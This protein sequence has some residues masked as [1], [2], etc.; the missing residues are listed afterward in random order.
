[1]IRKKIILSIILSCIVLLSGCFDS[2]KYPEYEI[3]KQDNG[4]YILNSPDGISY[5]TYENNIWY[6]IMPIMPFDEGLNFD[7]AIGKCDYGYIFETQSEA[8][9]FLTAPHERN[10][11]C[12]FLEGTALPEL[13]IENINNVVLKSTS[14]RDSQI[15]ADKQSAEKLIELYSNTETHDIRDIDSMKRTWEL[16][17]ECEQFRG[18]FLLKPIYTYGNDYYMYITY[19]YDSKEGITTNFFS[20]CTSEIKDILENN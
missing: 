15:I 5:V 4:Q 3:E 14:D 17:M 16:V 8:C 2:I 6:P 1:M 18:L 11:H 13:S 19:E 20:K 10:Q 7:D 9:L 12:F